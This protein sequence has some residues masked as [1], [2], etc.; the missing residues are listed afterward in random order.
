MTLFFSPPCL[1]GRRER[2]PEDRRRR[3]R[4]RQS[5]LAGASVAWSTVRSIWLTRRALALHATLAIV[6]PGF[7]ALCT[8]QVLRALS[9]NELSWVYVFE[10]PFFAGYAIYLW[11]KLVHEQ[12]EPAADQGSDMGHLGGTQPPAMTDGASNVEPL[13]SSEA[14]PT[15]E[16]LELEAYNRYLAELHTHGRPKRW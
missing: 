12:P 1:L 8:W 5:E 16:E 6:V 3:Q 15:R 9:G 7:F 11:W 10:W 14:E 13:P 2:P 4:R